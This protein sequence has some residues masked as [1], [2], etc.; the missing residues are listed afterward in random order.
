MPRTFTTGLNS[1]HTYYITWCSNSPLSKV[2]GF[3]FLSLYLLT[4]LW[5]KVF[6]WDGDG[7]DIT[8]KKQKETREWHAMLNGNKVF[9]FVMRE[10]SSFWKWGATWAVWGMD[11]NGEWRLLL[12]HIETFGEHSGD[13]FCSPLA[14]FRGCSSGAV[15]MSVFFLVTTVLFLS[16]V[17]GLYCG[18]LLNFFSNSSSSFPKLQRGY[19]LLIRHRWNMPTT[20]FQAFIMRKHSAICLSLL[21]FIFL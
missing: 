16:N 20:I 18:R 9:F 5:N 8:K 14:G 10:W 11:G 7:P 19:M 6:F 17:R 15:L 2:L 3:S 12:K 21:I 4:I 13:I 1:A